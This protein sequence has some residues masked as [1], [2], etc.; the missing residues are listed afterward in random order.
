R[1]NAN[2]SLDADFGSNGIATAN[3]G[4]TA[5]TAWA[6][7]QPDGKIDAVGSASDGSLQLARF[8]ADGSLD[9]TFGQGGLVA[10]TRQSGER[11]N[12]QTLVL[13]ADGG[14]VVSTSAGGHWLLVGYNANGSPNSSFGAGGFVRTPPLN[15]NFNESTNGYESAAVYP[16]AGTVN[17]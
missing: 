4:A 11:S 2:G 16:N 7:I 13:Q 3:F 10:T 15:P 5:G 1:Y 8:N 17:D 6:V 9:P 12:H 14:L